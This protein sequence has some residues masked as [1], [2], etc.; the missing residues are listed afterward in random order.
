MQQKEYTLNLLQLITLNSSS[1]GN[2]RLPKYGYNEYK[3]SY[4]DAGAEG[5]S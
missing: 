1:N 3:F 2:I 5:K 4:V